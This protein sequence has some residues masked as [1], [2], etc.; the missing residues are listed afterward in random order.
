[1]TMRTRSPLICECGNTGVHIHSENDQPYSEP[2]DRYELIGFT[3]GGKH[4]DDVSLMKCLGCGEIGRVK[5]AT[6]P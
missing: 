5:F 6:K 1:M 4:R 2:W 3:G